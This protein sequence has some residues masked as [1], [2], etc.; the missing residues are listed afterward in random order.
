MNISIAHINAFL[1]LAETLQFASAAER[2]HVSSSAFS[3]IIS[4]LE[5]D[6]GV[7][8]FD[9]TTRLVA[10]TSEGESFALG[11]KRIKSEFEAT[12]KELRARKSGRSGKVSVVATPTPCISWLP[13]VIWEFTE[14]H[15]GVEVRLHDGISDHCFA[16]LLEGHADIAITAEAGD[17]STFRSRPLYNESFSL[18]CLKGDPLSARRHVYLSDLAGRDFISVIGKG[19]VLRQRKQDLKAA[20]VKDSRFEVTNYSTLIGLVAAGFGIGLLPRM[21]L[22]LC[23]RPNLVAVPVKDRGF[24]RTFYLVELEGRSLSMAAKAMSA[25][26]VEHE[27][28]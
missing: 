19:D 21:A 25:F 28:G 7:R 14:Q 2:C 18:V 13:T 6:L 10:L 4:R 12:L 23:R 1:A 24:L 8:L 5:S 15:P 9:R 27:I 22:P 17:Q 26:L 16:M 11:A 20:G 3:Q